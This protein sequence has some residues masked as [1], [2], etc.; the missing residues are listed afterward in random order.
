MEDDQSHQ[1]KISWALQ[2]QK[3]TL[4]LTRSSNLS[5]SVIFSHFV[6]ALDP[7]GSFWLRPKEALAKKQFPYLNLIR[8]LELRKH[9]LPVLKSGLFDLI[10]NWLQTSFSDT[11]CFFLFRGDHRWG[12]PSSD[13]HRIGTGSAGSKDHG[14]GWRRKNWRL[15]QTHRR[16]TQPL[17]A[18]PYREFKLLLCSSWSGS[19]QKHFFMN[20][21]L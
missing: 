18:I 13:R 20:L 11:R 8:G 17:S 9:F 10:W 12:H 14:T 16:F 15:R 21:C 19:P 4:S 7:G 3:S 2:V 6:R 5:L 1:F